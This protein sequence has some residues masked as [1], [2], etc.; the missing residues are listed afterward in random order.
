MHPERCS[1]IE[2]REELERLIDLDLCICF[3]NGHY[4]AANGGWQK[5]DRSALDF[6]EAHIDHIPYLHFKNVNGQ[7]RRMILEE[8]LA[9]GDPKGQDVMCDLPDGIIDYVQF[10]D[11]LRA[12][13]FQGIGIIEQDVPNCTTAE[14]YE[15]AKKNLRYLQGI[16]L[17]A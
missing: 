1:L 17:I 15:K 5:G 14:A 9:P 13:D 6:L 8:H 10:R 3:D 4:A 2:T 11:L 7:V 16:G 12:L